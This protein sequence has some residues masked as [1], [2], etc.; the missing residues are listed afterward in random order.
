MK[1]YIAPFDLFNGLVKK[2]GI[3]EKGISINSTHYYCKNSCG[4]PKEIVETWEEYIEKPVFK[5]GD[6]VTIIDVRHSSKWVTIFDDLYN[7]NLVYL[8]YFGGFSEDLNYN[9]SVN[10]K[11]REVKPATVE[12]KEL[13]ISKLKEQGK[14]YDVSSHS[15]KDINIHQ[16]MIDEWEKDKTKIVQFSY[17]D[18]P[19]T[20]TCN[21]RPIWDEKAEYRF[22]PDLKYVPFERNDHKLFK[23]FWIK[24][25]DSDNLMRISGV[26]KNYI[27][28]AHRRTTY[29]YNVAL[30]VFV[31]EDGSPFGKL[32]EE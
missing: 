4:I 23:D 10:F 11:N 16:K 18:G 5:K 26:Y 25:K 1:K 17:K 2:G 9:R 6:F 22:K 29:D 31:F 3:Y 15:I 20:D 12:E 14:Y 32:V 19:W 30:E 28:I 21:N 7:D 8:V 24:K 27:V 13:L